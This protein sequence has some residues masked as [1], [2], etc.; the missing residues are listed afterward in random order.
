MACVAERGRICEYLGGSLRREAEEIRIFS[1]AFLGGS[2][3]IW[4]HL[5]GS[6]GGSLMVVVFLQHVWLGCEV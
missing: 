5:N 6:L 2:L 1:V 3:R 4:E